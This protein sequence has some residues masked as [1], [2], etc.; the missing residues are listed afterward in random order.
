M[1]SAIVS[2]ILLRQLTGKDVKLFGRSCC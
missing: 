1:N 2:A